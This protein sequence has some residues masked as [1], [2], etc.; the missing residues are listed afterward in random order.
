MIYKEEDNTLGV[1]FL[2]IVLST[3]TSV[4]RTMLIEDGNIISI[5]YNQT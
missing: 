2:D 3:V 4:F 5:T 1:S